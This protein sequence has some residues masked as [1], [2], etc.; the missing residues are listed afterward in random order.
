MQR[1]IAKQGDR[2][3]V[4]VWVGVLMVPFLILCALAIDIGAMNADR[5]RLQTGADAAALAVAQECSVAACPLTTAEAVAQQLAS[6][7]DPI[8]GTADAEII[9]LRPGYVELRTES[10]REQWFVPGSSEMSAVSAASWGHPS[11][12]TTLPFIFSSCQLRALGIIS[13][14]AATAPTGLVESAVGRTYRLTLSKANDA[15]CVGA[16]G[17]NMPGGFGWLNATSGCTVTTRIL[18]SFAGGTGGS[19]AST[20]TPVLRDEV[21]ER[22]TGLLPVFQSI[23]GVSGGGSNGNYK[24][25]AYIAVT[26]ERFRFQG[27]NCYPA[28]ACAT[29]NPGA[30]SGWI[31][32]TVRKYVDTDSPFET[33][34]TAP[35]IGTALIDLVIPEGG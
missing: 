24:V 32:V 17:L 26:L 15:G 28:S 12:G 25:V 5:Q 21:I 30:G 13:T 7:N 31:E 34:P 22:A 2:G 20:C 19:Q 33:S 27:Q 18:G 29:S 8:G 10:S 1:L 3:A 23:S 35:G 6:G 9:A 4:A 11:G 14:D 16:N